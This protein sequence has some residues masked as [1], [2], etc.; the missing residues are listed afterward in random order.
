MHLSREGRERASRGVVVVARGTV[1]VAA[2]LPELTGTLV[3]SADERDAR[4]EIDGEPR[5]FTP[6]VITRVPAGARR[7]RVSRSG[8]A[9][10]VRVG[11]TTSLEDVRLA[12]RREVAAASRRA[13]RVEDAPASVSIV[14]SEEI[15]RFAIPTVYEALRGIRGFA[16][17][18]DS[19]YHNASIRGLGQPNDYNS[20][21]LLLSD[22]ATLNEDILWQ[23][24]LGYDGRVDLGDVERIEIVRGPASVLYGTG[25]VSGVVNLVP[26]GRDEPTHVEASASLVEGHVAR[27]RASFTLR[28]D[29]DLGARGGFGIA[30]AEGRDAALFW[31]EDP[32]DGVVRLTP[33]VAHGTDRADAWTLNLRG[34]AGPLT[35][36]AFYTWREQRIPTG[37]FGT[38]F[39]RQED[40]Y[41]DQRGLLEVRF[42]P[43]PADTLQLYSR[44]YA[45][46]TGFDSFLIY[47]PARTTHDAREDYDGFWVGA[48]LRALWTP[49]PELRITLGGEG[50]HHPIAHFVATQ[51]ATGPMGEE[52]VTTPIPA[53]EEY[54]Y[55]ILSGTLLLDWLPASWVRLQ[56]GARVDGFVL[57]TAGN[58]TLAAVSPRLAA[59]FHLTPDDTLK[60][61]GGRAFRAP[62]VY[63][64]FFWD[65]GE[66]TLRST[67]FG[68]ALA[69]ED[70]T[71]AEIEYTHRFGDEWSALAAA[72]VLYAERFIDTVAAPPHPDCQASADGSGCVVYANVATE[73]IYAGG[74][75]EVRRELRGGWMF[76]AQYG[77]L[78]ARFV[79]PM[80]TDEGAL[81]SLVPNAPEHFFAMRGIAPLVPELLVLG[82]RL[83]VEAPRRA[84]VRD[85]V[86]TAPAIIADLVLS[87]EVASAGLSYSV[88]VYNLFDWGYALPVQPF[89][90]ADLTTLLAQR[91]RAFSASLSIAFR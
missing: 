74:D 65:G 48:E 16:L 60:I 55:T 23:S 42:E 50:S 81:D 91:G 37:S 53:G 88:G 31:D 13:E 10:E 36:Q 56:A 11:E 45:N 25:A 14:T 15:R 78:Q 90:S 73:Q 70:F 35:V 40:H 39:D 20:R 33:H 82:A 24:F 62:S 41:I 86:M 18:S 47:D 69:P 1:S 43:R 28:V 34:W 66:T 5:G 68:G 63:E 87:G 85:Q 67:A 29:D 6:A 83:S 57:A 58:R 38:A 51:Y 12:P 77:L 49:L 26:F 59:I 2:T 21:M 72:H 52:I 84:N 32:S 44:A 3:V 30:H 71:Q 64:Q 61:M 27:A 8:F 79:R 17:T 22:G 76:A 19:T 54:P 46:Y 9:P 75:V 7:V 4:V 89:V 80:P